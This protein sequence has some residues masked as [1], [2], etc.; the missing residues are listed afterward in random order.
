M[1]VTAVIPTLNPTR[2]IL[3][4]VEQLCTAGFERIIVVNDGSDASYNPI[5]DVI[6]SNP[7]CVVLRHV[8]NKGKG[9][10]LKSA[11]SYFGTK[12]LDHVGIITLDD[13]GQHAID[14]VVQCAQKLIEHPDSL[15]LGV[16]DFNSKNVPPKSKIGNK[17]TNSI[18]G[19][20]CGI[21]ISDTQT[22]LRG[23]SF[24]HMKLLIGVQGERFEYETNMLLNTK[25]L[26]IKIEE[27]TIKTIYM[28]ENSKSHFHPVRDSIK[29]YRQIFK[30][31]FS[32]ALSFIIDISLF[33]LLIAIL[34]FSEKNLIIF[35]AVL[36]SRAISSLVNFYTNKTIVFKSGA[37]T[38]SSIVR[39]YLL[40]IAQIM[41]SSLLIMLLT[42]PLPKIT[43]LVK[44]L[45]DT[46]LFF[47][48]Y[49]I[50]RN[51][52][53]QS[54]E[55]KK[56]KSTIARILSRVLVSILSVVLTLCIVLIVLVTMLLKGPSTQMSNIMVS[57]LME[58]SAL[59]F[60]PKIYFSEKEI[61]QITEGNDK[62]VKEYIAKV[63]KENIK[64]DGSTSSSQKDVVIEDVQGSTFSGKMVILKD[65]SRLHLFASNPNTGGSGKTVLEVM[66]ENE[67][68]IGVNGGAF[69]DIN[70]SGDG[71]TPLGTVIKDHKVITGYSSQ[72]PVLIGLDDS[73]QLF[74]GECTSE[75]ALNMGIRDAV[76]FG[77]VLV[78]NGEV[79]P[80]AGSGG[81]FNPRSAIGQR[82]D[83]A[84]LL[85]V[86]DGRQPHSLGATYNDL[87]VLMKKY[88][89][90]NAGNLDGGSSSVLYQKEE[91]INSL[92]S[93]V[94]ERP[95]PTAFY[96]K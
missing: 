67:A 90:I 26:K 75:E 9:R 53:F 42:V 66:K 84:I 89:A 49:K 20:F 19:L 14:D 92:S 4:T 85:L 25:K 23:I 52:V 64:I 3:Q 83:G 27:V 28:D 72:H 6:K 16:R 60:I 30:F 51:W 7:K 65:P 68:L 41:V 29:I 2:K 79:V 62:E 87:A 44:I 32:S 73:N 95:V 50:Q 45:V 34:P 48:S 22:G 33:T 21:K 54:Q 17:I 37:N 76:S 69:L 12:P 24:Q 10:A 38:G 80:Q 46:F 56:E 31:V 82:K 74:V 91:R 39:Y 94:G 81:G 40:C 1:N 63:H 88:E 77:P 8:V 57:T 35:F 96:Y 15:I 11:M 59:K 36:I 70:G 58:T 86:I 18:F 5:F 47:I 55:T 71:S 43:V 13:D 93:A 78:K 61:K